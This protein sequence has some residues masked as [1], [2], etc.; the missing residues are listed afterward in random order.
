MTV[1]DKLKQRDPHS[2]DE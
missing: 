2:N 1:I